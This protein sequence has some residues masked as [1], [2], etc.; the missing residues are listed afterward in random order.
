MHVVKAAHDSYPNLWTAHESQMRVWGLCE[1]RLQRKRIEMRFEKVTAELC[2]RSSIGSFCSSFALT[3]A[4]WLAQYEQQ[5]E[6]QRVKQAAFSANSFSESETKTLLK[7]ERWREGAR[8]STTAHGTP[9]MSGVKPRISTYIKNLPHSIGF[10]HFSKR[11]NNVG[12][13][14]QWKETCLWFQDAKNLFIDLFLIDR[15]SLGQRAS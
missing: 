14:W 5:P 9:R 13:F 3:T 2:N 15:S 8:G 11:W 1:R 7:P 4:T 10:N 12:P 6:Q